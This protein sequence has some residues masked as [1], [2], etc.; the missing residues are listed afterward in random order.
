[1][2]KLANMAGV[3]VDKSVRIL[4]KMLR[5]DREGWRIHGLL[6]PAKRI[7]EQAVRTPGDARDQAVVLID[8]L[9]RRGYTEFGELLP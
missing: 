6:D 7:L 9:G 1:L 5:A 4:D 3:D 8:F 2:E